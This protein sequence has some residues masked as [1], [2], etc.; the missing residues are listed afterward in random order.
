MTCFGI[1]AQYIDAC[2]MFDMFQM[3]LRYHLQ[4]SLS[5][6]SRFE[7]YGVQL[8]FQFGKNG[9]PN[10]K[11]ITTVKFAPF[12][13]WRLNVEFIFRVFW[14][15]SCFEEAIYEN[16]ELAMLTSLSQ[17]RTSTLFLI[18]SRSYIAFY[19]AALP[20]LPNTDIESKIG[21]QRLIYCAISGRN[22]LY[23][24]ML[25]RFR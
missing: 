11:Q 25:G 8:Y 22:R 6:C 19:T 4:V 2:R 10:T 3:A 5:Q 7:A 23:F 24:V 9:K 16:C 15:A 13:D 20:Q 1:S 17:F 12:E 18:S 14:F 21:L